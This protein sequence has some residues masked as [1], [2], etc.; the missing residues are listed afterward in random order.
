MNATIRSLAI[1]AGIAVTAFFFFRRS[2]EQK[3]ADAALGFT[4]ETG[5]VGS[6]GATA[7]R[8]SGGLFSTIGRFIGDKL[9]P[10][11]RKT[12]DELTPAP[13]TKGIVKGTKPSFPEIT[14]DG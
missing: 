6:L 14:L 11:N 13:T 9:D 10:I 7:N 4:E 5:L 1:G 2:E 3:K 8:A 12:L